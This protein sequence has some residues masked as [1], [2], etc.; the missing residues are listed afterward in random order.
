[1]KDE[2]VRKPRGFNVSE[3][4]LPPVYSAIANRR[5]AFD[6]MMWQ[7]PAL[8]LAAQ[9][10]LLTIAYGANSSNA[11]RCVSGALSVVVALV[12]IQTMNKHRANELTD[13]RALTILELDS[14]IRLSRDATFHSR[15]SER[16]AAVENKDLER[17]WAKRRSS[18]LWV[19]SLGGFALAG[20]LAIVLTICDPG[21]LRGPDQPSASP[22]G[23]LA[24]PGVSQAPS[25]GR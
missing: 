23:V 6:T 18:R 7:V 2:E 24:E 21:T 13:S 14:G 19:C 25:P 10:F 22:S 15:P 8:G 11:A 4:H 16:G 17:W 12:A 5:T 1:M 3:R 9:A 20:A